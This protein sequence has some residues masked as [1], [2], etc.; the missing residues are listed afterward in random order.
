MKTIILVLLIS[1]LVGCSKHNVVLKKTHTVQEKA[2]IIDKR[3][4]NNIVKSKKNHISKKNH[5][6]TVFKSTLSSFIPLNTNSEEKD[7]SWQQ[8]LKDYYMNS[9][10]MYYILFAI[11]FVTLG[12]LM[13][14]STKNKHKL[15]KQDL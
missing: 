1:F 5:T 2:Q 15:K 3:E 11:S 7:I 6:S 10:I 14:I 9:N 8:M 12:F 4:N 13:F